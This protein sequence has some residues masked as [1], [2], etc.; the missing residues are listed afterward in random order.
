MDRTDIEMKSGRGGFT[1]I[2]MSIVLVI[3]GLLVG[4]VLVGQD[5]IRAAYIR[6]QITQIEK[7]NTA[8]NTF[9]GKYQA[10]PGDMNASTA[11]EFGFATRGA[12]PGEGDG[13][14]IIEGIILSGCGNNSGVEIFAGETQ[15]FWVDLSSAVAGN[16]I[17]GGFNQ[18]NIL[19]PPTSVSTTQMPLYFPTAN[20][21]GGNYIYVWSGGWK[22]TGTGG[23]AGP[24]EISDGVNY[25]G[26]SVMI[27]EGLAQVGLTVSQ[28]YNIDTKIDDGFPQSGRV[29]A[30]D[31]AAR[32]LVSFSNAWAAGG[33]FGM[34][35][36]DPTTHGPVVAGDGVSTPG[37]PTTC[38]DNGG[39]SGGT[40]VYSTGYQGG[41]NLNCA[42]SF[43]MQGGD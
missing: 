34:G 24:G 7:F 39:A 19:A 27:S 31:A 17:G 23:D 28:A 25:F 18:N 10:L 4:G 14:G 35:A 40:E 8:V 9:Y 13:N 21:G 42:L 1:L 2:E 36:Q 37:S 32:E 11:T 20:I 22:E 5:L 16:L 3:V 15:M 33:S 43:K 6:A 30:L 41:A 38:Y 29:L 26:I 12:C